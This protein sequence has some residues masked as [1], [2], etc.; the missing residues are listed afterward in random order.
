M[1]VGFHRVH[2]GVVHGPDPETGDHTARDQAEQPDPGLLTGYSPIPTTTT[3]VAA[4]NTM[5]GTS[6]RI[7]APSIERPGIATE[8]ITQMPVP[9]M[10]IEAR[11]G[12]ANQCRPRRACFVQ[13]RPRAQPVTGMEY[14]KAGV[15]RP[16]AK[17]SR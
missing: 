4:P 9:P 1:G 10:V 8:Y 5:S 16:N 3:E 11:A 2:P 17:C 13:C 15:G 7:C 12:Q 14:A 6:N